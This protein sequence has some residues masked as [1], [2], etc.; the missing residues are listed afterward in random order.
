M[1]EMRVHSFS[2]SLFAAL[3]SF[4]PHAA[5]AQTGSFI[6]AQHGKPVGT[7]TVTFS[8]GPNGLDTTSVVRVDMQGLKYS[9]SKNEKLSAANQLRHVDVSANVNGSAVNLTAA[10]DAAQILLNVSA[11]G[12]SSAVRLAT[13]AGAV[14]LPDFDPGAFDTLL[15]LAVA[16]N[17]RALWAIIPKQSGTQAG[18]QVP[19]VLATYADM[20]GTVD[21]KPIAVHHLVA[22]IG[23]AKTD[24][25]SGP[26]NQLLQAEL[27]QQGFALVR[28]GFVLTPPAKA[29]APP[30]SAPRPA[31]AAAPAA[32]QAPVSQ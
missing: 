1:R 12:K 16:Q 26:K 29:G 10:P 23:G 30:V 8:A 4:V 19:V 21:G 3:L 25:F 18:T 24:L 28:K 31:P 9:L 5:A 13:H 27:P 15:A 7:A 14:F 6:I 22:T 2:L 11:S 32:P 17:N 20:N